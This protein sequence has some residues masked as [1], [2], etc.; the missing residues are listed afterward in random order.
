MLIHYVLWQIA[1]D[2]LSSQQITESISLATYHDGLLFTA[3]SHRKPASAGT[4]LFSSS[5]VRT[6]LKEGH[7][8]STVHLN[9]TENAHRKTVLSCPPRNIRTCTSVTTLTEGDRYGNDF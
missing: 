8:M 5:S 1:K 4:S 9:N 7:C 2:F 6:V 3:W